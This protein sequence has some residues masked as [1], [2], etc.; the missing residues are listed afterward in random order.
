MPCH[1]WR[2]PDDHPRPDPPRSITRMDD[3]Q[4]AA[5][6]CVNNPRSLPERQRLLDAGFEARDCLG[7]CSACFETRFVMVGARVIEGPDYD[8]IIAQALA[9]ADKPPPGPT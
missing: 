5:R 2:D 8:T 6:F 7:R 4:G 1:P 3:H 9:R